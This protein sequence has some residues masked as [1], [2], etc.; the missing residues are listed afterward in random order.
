MTLIKFVGLANTSLQFT[1]HDQRHVEFKLLDEV[2]DA[3][4][5]CRMIRSLT[6]IGFQVFHV[7]TSGMEKC[8]NS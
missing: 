3:L 6:I 1:G 7:Y 4:L 2:Q 8:K 5:S